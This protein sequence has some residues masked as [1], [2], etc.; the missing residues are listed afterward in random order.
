MTLG[1]TRRTPGSRA[2]AAASSSVSSRAMPLNA[3][4]YWW[5]AATSR[6]TRPRTAASALP[7][8]AQALDER[9]LAG[10]PASSFLSPP[11][12]RR[13][14]PRA[15]PSSGRCETSRP[16][17]RPA[18]IGRARHQGQNGQDKSDPKRAMRR[19]ET[20]R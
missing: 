18:A 16:F 2:I 12:A 9:R 17:L 1:C 8:L 4:V 10:L 13:P 7:A 20:S 15:G 3:R 6:P 11:L 19:P 14:A 5:R